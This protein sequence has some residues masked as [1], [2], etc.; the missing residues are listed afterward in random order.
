MDDIQKEHAE[1]KAREDKA[2]KAKEAADKAKA[3]AKA[4]AAR[5]AQLNWLFPNEC[6]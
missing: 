3:E 6:G 2:K 4:E 5:Q 1:A